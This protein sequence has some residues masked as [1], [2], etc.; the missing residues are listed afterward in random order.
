MFDTQQHTVHHLYHRYHIRARRLSLIQQRIHLQL[1]LLALG[2]GAGAC[3]ILQPQ[4][5][6]GVQWYAH[7]FAASTYWDLSRVS[8]LP[9][10]FPSWFNMGVR[11]LLI[12]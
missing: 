9:M 11:I 3:L 10:L 7:L 1:L 5:R 4:T 8:L 6:L 12:P 2:A